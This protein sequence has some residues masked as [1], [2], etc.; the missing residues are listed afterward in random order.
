MRTGL[1]PDVM[2]P[3]RSKSNAVM[4][5]AWLVFVIVLPV[6]IVTTPDCA[7]AALLSESEF[8]TSAPLPVNAS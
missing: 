5:T 2:L 6:W 4:V 3:S 1:V 7:F 8:I